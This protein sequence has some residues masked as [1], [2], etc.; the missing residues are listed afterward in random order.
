MAGGVP[1][2]P[3]ILNDLLQEPEKRASRI[4][5]EEIDREAVE[6]SRH[7]RSLGYLE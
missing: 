2:F 4:E 7:L 3:N 5:R 6:I 1:D